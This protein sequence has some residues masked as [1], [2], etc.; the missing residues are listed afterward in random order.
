[1]V[2]YNN[3]RIELHQ[4]ETNGLKAHTEKALL[5]YPKTTDSYFQAWGLEK[6]RIKFPNSSWH[7]FCSTEVVVLGKEKKFNATVVR[8]F[9]NAVTP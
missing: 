6:A 1:M 5:Y 4:K 2:S 3:K 8:G 9:K 7:I